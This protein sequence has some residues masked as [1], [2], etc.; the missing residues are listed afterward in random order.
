MT[1]SV[2]A[3]PSTTASHHCH[4][5]RSPPAILGPVDER[6]QREDENNA[7][8]AQRIA[9]AP[10]RDSIGRYHQD[11]HS[12]RVTSIPSTGVGPTPGGSN[13]ASAPTKDSRTRAKA[14]IR[15]RWWVNGPFSSLAISPPA[16]SFDD[17]VGDMAWRLISN[18]CNAKT[19]GGARGQSRRA[20]R[21]GAPATAGRRRI[22]RRTRNRHLQGSGRSPGCG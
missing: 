10:Q 19:P 4:W 14:P 12:G 7:P 5:T 21:R 17:G 3:P 6:H 20:Q 22:S 15:R 18:A 11:I 1:V 8:D 13:T 9:F 2:M 16:G